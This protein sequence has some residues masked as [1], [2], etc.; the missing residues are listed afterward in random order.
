MDL[1]R[2]FFLLSFLFFITPAVSLAGINIHH[3]LKVKLNPISHSLEVTDELTFPEELL[4]GSEIIIY[5][6]ESLRLDPKQNFVTIISHDKRFP[7]PVRAYRLSLKKGESSVVLRYTGSLHHELTSQGEDYARSFSETAGMIATEGVFLAGPSI[8]YPYIEAAQVSFSLKVK[9]PKGWKVISQGDRLEQTDAG[10]G[11]S[12]QWQELNPQE[13]IYLIAAPFHEYSKSVGKVE[14]MAFLRQADTALANKYLEVTAQ[15][16]EMYRHLL[17]PYPY[18]KF[19]LV[20]NFWETG[21][22]MPSFTLLGSRVIRMPFILHSSYPHEILH[23]WWGNGV[24]VDYQQGNWAEGLTSYL[25]DHLIQQQRGKAVS[26]RRNILQNYADFVSDS[27]GFPLAEFT[28]RHGSSSEAI[29]YGKSQMF[30][31]MLRQKLGDEAFVLGLQRLYRQYQFKEAGFDDLLKV[32]QTVSDD[33]LTALFR[34]WVQRSGAPALQLGEV[35]VVK[36]QGDWLL[37]GMLKQVQEGVAYQLT[38]PVAVSLEDKEAAFQTN[39]VLTTKQQTFSLKLAAKPLRLDIDPEFDLFRRVSRAEIPP[40]LSQA[41][42]ADRV[43][44]VLPSKASAETQAAYEALIKS[45]GNSQFGKLEAVYDD[46]LA[47]LPDDRTIWLLGGQ[48]LFANKV[49]ASLVGQEV[50]RRAAT[51]NL[52]ER[53]FDLAQYS[54]VLTARRHKEDGHAMVWLA[55]DRPKAIPGLARK[56]PHYRKYS[57]LVFDGDEPRNVIKGQWP[58]LDSPM[59]VDLSG[60]ATKMTSLASRP[61]LAQLPALFD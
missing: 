37:R 54:I 39:L 20:E 59:S 13:E 31:H 25:A 8:W 52:N 5:L 26:F 46:A 23:N 32:F 50:T 27:R 4:A 3:D 45:W 14:A 53:A 42:G 35:E 33:D 44:F 57:Y 22:G 51:I 41:F 29:G 19:A 21:Y 28:S 47:A 43:L 55:A 17:G 30:F 1:P 24:Y 11:H 7:V 48:N 15:Y 10:Q 60:A 2:K 38:V 9:S 6:N 36:D 34:Q 61:A 16:I 40:A 49:V 58:V 18:N 56:L 12:V